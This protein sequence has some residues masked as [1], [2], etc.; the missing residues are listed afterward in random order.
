M[1]IR[2]KLKENTSTSTNT[3][4]LTSIRTGTHMSTAMTDHGL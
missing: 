2:K 3:L 4:T 1:H